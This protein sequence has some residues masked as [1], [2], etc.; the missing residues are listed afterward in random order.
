M[1]KLPK[2]LK[3]EIIDKLYQDPTVPQKDI[4]I[5]KL[6]DKAYREATY[7]VELRN[8]YSKIKKEI[9]DQFISDLQSNEMNIQKLI[10]LIEKFIKDIESKVNRRKVAF[11]ISMG[12]DQ[13]VY[14]WNKPNLGEYFMPSGDNLDKKLV[15]KKGRAVEG[16]P[17]IVRLLSKTPISE[18]FDQVMGRI[19]DSW[20]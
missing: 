12:V 20:F 9:L 18:I 3:K 14:E 11:D 16:D 10:L 6:I 7:E 17:E 2:D 1:D 5:L 15:L 13:I 4:H 8:Q 19:F